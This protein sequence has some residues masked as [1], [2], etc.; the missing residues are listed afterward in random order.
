M[1]NYKALSQ[2]ES[3]LE[4]DPTLRVHPNKDLAFARTVAAIKTPEDAMHV[5]D[6]LSAKIATSAIPDEA[7]AT[8]KAAMGRLN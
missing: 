4:L 8:L 3:D 6:L 7:K 2:I 5:W 1:R